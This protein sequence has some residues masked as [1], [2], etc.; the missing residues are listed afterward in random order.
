ME[1]RMKELGLAMN[2]RELGA[3]EEM[4]EGIATGTA[5]ITRRFS[6]FS[7][8][9]SVSP[10]FL[11]M[12]QRSLSSGRT[13][14]PF[15]EKRVRNALDVDASFPIVQKNTVAA[16]IVTAFMYQLTHPAVLR[17]IHNRNLIVDKTPPS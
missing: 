10:K 15:T 4:L 12:T 8:F 1:S 7:S 17:I 14:K 11:V 9:H 6:F 5:V 13:A 3:T 2:L 16:V